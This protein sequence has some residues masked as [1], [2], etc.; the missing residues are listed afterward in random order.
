MKNQSEIRNNYR[1]T[2]TVQQ[3]KHKAL[4]A[5][6]DQ[7]W[8]EELSKSWIGI[9]EECEWADMLQEKLSCLDFYGIQVRD[10]SHKKFLLTFSEKIDLNE[11]CKNR[12]LRIFK[13]IK[14]VSHLD[15]VV[16]RLA[17]VWCDGL[18]IV[19]WNKETWGKI[20]GD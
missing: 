10:I 12:L 9:T 18:P 6:S 20:I 13:E 16:P 11:E 2:D 5:D 19:A 17:W 4:I 8:K 3:P 15:L 7:I 14:A 1:E